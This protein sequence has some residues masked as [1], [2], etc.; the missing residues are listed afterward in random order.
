[1]AGCWGRVGAQIPWDGYT[2]GDIEDNVR[3]GGRVPEL[4]RAKR[5]AEGERW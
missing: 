4:V 3:G 1:M 5:G 2:N